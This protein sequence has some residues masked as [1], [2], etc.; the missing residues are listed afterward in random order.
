MILTN[1]VTLKAS[2]KHELLFKEQAPGAVI[3][4]LY[5]LRSLRICQVS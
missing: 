1:L 4:T 5:S 2:A 3:T